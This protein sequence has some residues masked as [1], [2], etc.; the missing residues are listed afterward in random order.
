M[1]IKIANDGSARA[2]MVMDIPTEDDSLLANVYTSLMIKQ[3]TWFRDLE[4]GSRLHLLAR[5]KNT[6]QTAALAE[7]YA[8]EALQWLITA[9]KATTIDVQAMRSGLDR[10]QLLVSV[11]KANGQTIAFEIFTE[12]V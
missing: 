4:F 2:E 9:K 8:K 6:E 7:E 10:L 1:I 5:A 12:V 11:T 3:G